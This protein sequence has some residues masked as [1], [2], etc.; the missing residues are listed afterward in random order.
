MIPGGFPV[1]VSGEVV[2]K[3]FELANMGLTVAALSAV[4]GPLRLSSGRR[5]RLLRTYVP[6][7][8]KCGSSARALISVVILSYLLLYVVFCLQHKLCALILAL[9]LFVLSL[10]SEPPQEG[11]SIYKLAIQS[12]CL[13]LLNLPV[14]ILPYQIMCFCRFLPLERK[15]LSPYM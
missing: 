13:W 7:A 12:M 11:I 9:S 5:G 6:W 14:R 10:V 3:W 4:F 2:V 8:L 1:S 15:N